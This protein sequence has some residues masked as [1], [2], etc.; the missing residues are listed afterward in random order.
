MIDP[1]AGAYA[2]NEN[3]RA[4]VRGFLSHWDL[5]ARAT[6]C[7]VLLISHPPKSDADYSGSTDWHAA[8]RAVWTLGVAETGTGEQSGE[9]RRAKRTP[10]PA[11]RLR[12]VKSSYS[13]RPGEHWL[14]GYPAWRVV[15]AKEAARE[16]KR[17]STP[18]DFAA[19]NHRTLSDRTAAILGGA[20]ARS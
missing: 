12:C 9:G 18:M 11:P 8:S 10:A 20:G 7:S 14:A 1:T 19:E 17:V 4:L 3:D 6:G 2:L 15:D 13:R 5:W 16:W